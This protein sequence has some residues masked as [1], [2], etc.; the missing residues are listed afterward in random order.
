MLIS[1]AVLLMEY[2][3]VLT[4]FLIESKGNVFCFG[5]TRGDSLQ[6][7]NSGKVDQLNKKRK[8]NLTY[9]INKFYC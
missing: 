6:W 2:F 8:V 3:G 4:L 1:A 5:W 9:I 7:S